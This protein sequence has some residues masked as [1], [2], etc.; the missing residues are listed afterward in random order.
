IYYFL[1]DHDI[2][3]AKKEI[4]KS[5]NARNSTWQYS[6]AFLAAY[7]GDL[8]QAH[9][10][11]QRAFRGQVTPST[12]LEVETFIHDVLEV[13]PDKIQLWYC[14]DMI[15]YFC[16]GDMASTR[17]DFV[18]FIALASA[19]NRF[20]TSIAFARKYLEEIGLEAA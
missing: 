15:N 4:K 2:D 10:I 7:E 3:K 8:E 6:A 12:P 14:L 11:Y 13:E 9:K 19:Q 1:H 20:A 17:N 5:K 16:K 18:Q